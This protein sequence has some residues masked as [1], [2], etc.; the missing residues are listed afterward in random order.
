M[1]VGDRVHYT[2]EGSRLRPDGSQKYTSMC[3]CADITEVDQAST[4]G[5]VGLHVVSPTG[6]HWR[7]LATGGA[8]YG[9]LPGQWHHAESCDN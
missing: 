6:Q 9:A 8:Y 3:C 5:M 7:S 2:S 4:G 1:K